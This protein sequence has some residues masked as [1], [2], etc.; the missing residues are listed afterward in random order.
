[1]R[2]LLLGVT[3]LICS[4]VALSAEDTNTTMD[5][6]GFA[7]LDTGYQSK[8]NDPDW[9]DVVRPTNLPAFDDQFGRRSRVLDRPDGD[10]PR[11]VPS[12][13]DQRSGAAAVAVAR[14]NAQFDDRAPLPVRG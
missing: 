4:S 9:F 6:Y 11:V 5:I 10:D 1:M 14:S 12:D 7:M 2:T 3:S 8:Q 13:A